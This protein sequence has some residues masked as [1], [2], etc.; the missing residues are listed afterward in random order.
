VTDTWD[1]DDRAIARALGADGPDD[2]VAVD[3]AVVADY[4][5]VLAHL[6]FEQ[7]APAADLEDR[8]VAAAL[9]R[10]P[11]TARALDAPRRR[12]VSRGWIGAAAAAVA[13]AAIVV[14]LIAG[15]SPSGPGAP[16]GRIESAAASGGVARVLADPGTRKGVLRAADGA[17]GG[18][19]ALDPHGSG[20]LTGLQIPAANTTPWLWLETDSAP[21]P[22]GSIPRSATV[23]FVVRGDVEAVRGVIVSTGADAPEPVSLRGPLSK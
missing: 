23:H 2:E 5:E 4:E 9:E 15:R 11:A 13:A 20:Y 8:V 17:P 7:A 3:D 21:V 16:A 1:D 19:V 6:P 14:V 12:H 18:R 10:R 22:V